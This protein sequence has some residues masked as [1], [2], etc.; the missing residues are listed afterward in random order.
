MTAKKT[1]TKTPDTDTQ[2]PEQPAEAKQQ[3]EA[4]PTTKD[5]IVQWTLHHDNKRYNA[6][7]TLAL[8]IADA[9]PLLAE[10]VIKADG[11]VVT[12][13]VVVAKK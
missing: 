9:T 1:A 13:N 5:Y 6:G 11:M 12:D 2:T 10:G 7:D 8:S 4:K 3:V